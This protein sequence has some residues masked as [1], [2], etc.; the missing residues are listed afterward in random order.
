MAAPLLRYGDC[1]DFASGF[2]RWSGRFRAFTA[3]ILRGSA[4]QSDVSDFLEHPLACMR[5][6]QQE[7]NRLDSRAV[8]KGRDYDL[9]GTSYDPKTGE[10]TF[11]PR[12]TEA[13]REAIRKS[14]VQPP[15]AEMQY[16]LRLQRDWIPRI[17]DRYSNSPTAIVLT[18][19]PSR[20]V[21]RA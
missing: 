2:Q 19:L 9:V 14:L 20:S 11:P 21:R 8:Y 3:C 17:L 4:Y 1:F 10:V 7:P 5:S 18:P 15:Q 16:F 13:Q 12:L 6:I